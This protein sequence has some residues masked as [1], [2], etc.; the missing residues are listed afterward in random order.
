MEK[1]PNPKA[2]EKQG[3][4]APPPAKE[5]EAKAKEGKTFQGTGTEKKG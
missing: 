2:D 5:A 4:K 3:D 1:N